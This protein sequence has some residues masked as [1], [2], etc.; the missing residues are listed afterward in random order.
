LAENE[1]Q[2]KEKEKFILNSIDE[3]EMK[4]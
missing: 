1:N 4:N 2:E 3:G